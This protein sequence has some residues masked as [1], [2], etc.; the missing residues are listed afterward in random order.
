[1]TTL[2]D[3]SLRTILAL[4]LVGAAGCAPSEGG[5]GGGDRAYDDDDDGY[6][7]DDDDQAGDDDVGD[8]D[9]AGADE[10]PP[11]ENEDDVFTSEPRGT[12]VYVF[13]PNP[14][15]DT[16]SKIHAFERTIE[17][18]EVGDEPVQVVVSADFNRAITFN[19]GSDS[20]SI[21]DVV[22]GGVEE[23]DVREDFNFI[24][25][26]PDGR[27]VVAW[28]NA[29]VE[30]A[31]FDVEGVRSF[32]EVSFVDTWNLQVESYSVGFN[33]TDIQ[34][35]ADSRRAVLISDTFL[36]VADL[37]S[38]P[39]A[40]ELLDLGADPVDPPTVGEVE[41][42]PAGRYAFVR[43]LERDAIQVVDLDNGDL[44][45]LDGG[46]S[47]SD[48]D[49]T[50][51]GEQVI[52]VA[53]ASSE[54]RIFDTADPFTATPTILATPATSTLGSLVL[55]PDGE[56]GLLFSNAVLEDRVTFWDRTTD[57]LVERALV[58]PVE[59]VAV[60]PDGESALII[61]TLDDVP[62]ADD[63]FTH[64]HA[65]TVVDLNTWLSNP[66]AL[67]GKPR[68]WINSDD[69]QYALFLMD[70]NRNVGVVD[71]RT[72]L[73]DDVLV[74]SQPVH[75]GVMPIEGGPPVPTGWVSQDHELG[76]I[77]FLELDDLA[78]QTVTGFELN[79]DIE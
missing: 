40:L 39:I 49:L 6:V 75:V 26:S 64:R 59:S 73:V 46:L 48:M 35:S 5:F 63:V 54:L 53:R 44:G 19:A 55:S 47:P 14:G 70:N 10:E 56:R 43:Y 77:S 65:I 22:G 79:S 1:M 31:T 41:V 28:F 61:H 8:D 38:E 9:A 42:T 52:V 50:P 12:D 74:P 58:K 21:I 67:Q 37:S 4:A 3:V 60:S 71:Y 30:D 34:F 78:V 17:T 7:Y 16:V 23:I 57:T 72:R 66:V 2:S 36:T 11:P 62:D 15:R 20:V 27:W 29:K 18:I 33:P 32:T 25:M 45:E 76:R 24:Q 13:I 51:G 69:G 68:R